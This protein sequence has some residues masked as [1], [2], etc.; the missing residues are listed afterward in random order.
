[1][2]EQ[3]LGRVG[4][5]ARKSVEDG[6]EAISPKTLAWKEALND[7]LVVKTGSTLPALRERQGDFEDW[8]IS[9]LNMPPDRVRVVDVQAGA[10]LPEP[11]DVAGV[12][13]TGSHA[14][15][16]DHEPWS[17][18]AA[19]WLRRAVEQQTP[20]LGICYGHQLL[21]YALGGDVGHN[22]H[23]HETGTA[24]VYLNEAGYAD[25]LL[26]GLANPL[27]V[28]VS[29]QQTVLRLPPGAKRLAWS[30]R[31]AHQAFLVG[32]NAW[33]VQFHPEFNADAVRAYARDDQAILRAEGQ[34]PAWISAQVEET[35]YG[36]RI[37]KRFAQI[38]V[39]TAPAS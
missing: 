5:L 38:A 28:Q 26:G 20:M 19:A 9:G 10:V 29:H 23:G 18:R 33:G 3:Q 14:M 15:V 17:E 36:R 7:I 4:S 16:T 8:V 34:D 31:D 11:G 6:A 22:P 24:N 25:R 2:N 12:I 37:L 13:I 21:A 27:R 35:I 32:D 39:G 30:D 1:V